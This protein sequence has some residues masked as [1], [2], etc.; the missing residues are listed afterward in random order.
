MRGL[1]KM[2][3]RRKTMLKNKSRRR[4]AAGLERLEQR[5]LP[6]ADV[7]LFTDSFESGA[8]SNDWA[9]AWVEDSQNDWFRSSQ[10]VT[11]GTVSAEVDGY[12]SNAT[13]TMA[14]AI[15]LSGYDSAELTFDWLIESGFDGGEY[16]SLDVSSNG[17]TSWQTD[18]RRLSGN[19]DAENT[20]H[21]ETVDL[22]PYASSNLLI[23]FRSLVSRSN[24]DANVDNVKIVGTQS[25]PP[26]ISISDATVI[27]GDSGF[28][29]DRAFISAGSGGLVSPRGI[30]FGP[31]GRL[32]VASTDTDSILRYDE[33]TGAFIDEFVSTGSGGL[34]F[35]RDITFHGGDLFVA[36]SSTHSV[37]RY[38]GVTGDFVSEFVT[39]GD[40]GLDS[41]RGLLFGP[42]NDLYV[43]S[44][45]ED[46]AVLR[47]D[48]TDGTFLSEFIVSGDNGLANPS[49]IAIGPDGNFYVSSTQ[50][51]SNAVLRYDSAGSFIDTFIGPGSGGLDGPADLAFRSGLLY[52]AGWRSNSIVAYD[53]SSGDYVS[54]VT[55]SAGSSPISI[56]FDEAGRLYSSSRVTDEILRFVEPSA[57]YLDVTLSLPSSEVVTVEFSTADG[58]AVAGGDYQSTSDTLTFSPGVTSQTVRIPVSADGIAEAD[59]FFHVMLENSTN[60]SIADPVGQVTIAERRVSVSNATAIEGDDTP[61]YR[62][63]FVDGLPSGHF[64]P[65][66]FGPDGNI[67]TAVGTGAGY[68]T[69]Q[70]FDG[71]TGAF[72]DTF[73]DNSN[74]DHRINGV[75]DI[76]FHPTDG[77]VYVASAYTDEVLRYDAITGEF[78]DVFVTPGNGGI[79]HPDGMLFG[80]D[81]NNDGLPELLVTGWLS[82]NVVRYD[83]A[84][85]QPLGNYVDT[86]SGGLNVAFSL[87]TCGD[88][89]FVTSG[90]T[91]QILKYDLH[92]GQFLGVAASTGIDYPRGL[93]FGPDDLLYV[94]SGDNDRILRFTP[95]GTYVDDYVPA[96][97]AGFDNPRTPRFGPDGDLYVTMTGNNEIMRFGA[98]NE[99]VFAVTLSLPSNQPVSVSYTTGPNGVNPATEG[100]DYLDVTGRVEFPPGLTEQ[101][102]LVPI[103]DDV[104]HES[105]EAFAIDLTSVTGASVGDG[106]GVGTIIDNEV[107]NQPP[108]VS[109]GDDQ[110]FIDNDGNGNETV[111]VLG[112]ASDSDG[113]IVAVEWSDGTNTLGTSATL[114]TTLAVGVHTLTLTATD[115]EGATASDSVTV[116][117]SPASSEVVLFED[118]FEIGANNNDWNGKWVEDSQDDFFRSTQ[119]ATDG[120]RSAEVDGQAT[121]A[122]LTQLTSIDTS[123]FTSTELTFD[124][125]IEKGFDSGEYLSLD[126]STDGGSSWTQDVRRLSGN[127]D[128]EN[129]WHSE[130]VDLSAYSAS[131]L[132]VRFRSYVSGS[133]E[134]ANIDNVKIVGSSSSSSSSMLAFPVPETSR[135]DLQSEPAE[136]TVTQTIELSLGVSDAPLQPASPGFT[137][138]LLSSPATGSAAATDEALAEDDL[139]DDL[140]LN[141]LE[142]F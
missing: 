49:E 37:L 56:T 113:S 97:T 131:N 130:T 22:T 126:V 71:S 90:G 93:T 112:S 99:A 48:S 83:G 66:T 30:T 70:R 41:P 29:L 114:T 111:T 110:T 44:A 91:N 139:L 12:A 24:E 54:T 63:A 87:A 28:T 122:T 135:N 23:R 4:L 8:N 104:L 121:N 42:N 127:M 86:G 21:N 80:P 51:A 77:K 107:P 81:A 132:L 52:V 98:R 32:Y 39:S 103:L 124:W 73:M 40:G 9:G 53:S 76:V 140:S 117:V 138:E 119:R 55:A 18:V 120:V 94:T 2:T 26:Q 17:G 3:Q 13:L 45:G 88:E 61:H 123:G 96:A 6:A 15:D 75:R 57:A 58:S 134:D 95:S 100:D 64:N 118:S 65:L 35:P 74:P 38:D 142:R 102:V 20:W 67:Y 50:S 84:T 31:D 34:D 69:I 46:D 33:G 14:N 25:G 10:R 116:T 141:L 72:I 136:E 1:T 101:I 78:V 133:R 79:D 19:V 16:L 115:N 128:A 59:E 82:D 27:E 125:L 62:G 105:A 43:T 7:T 92:T 47:Y 36:S 68:N 129:T 5:Q 109:A 60:A 108:V 137:P 85:G 89:L 106:Q 11:E